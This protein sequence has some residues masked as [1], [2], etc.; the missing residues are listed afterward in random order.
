M[1][2][3]LAKTVGK[4]IRKKRREL[5]YTLC[6]VQKLTGVTQSFLSG[7]ER[8]EALPS[9]STAMKISSVLG[10]T[11]NDIVKGSEEDVKTS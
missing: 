10:L 7:V 9:L 2:K 8:G 1:N 6:Y 4:N 5:D 3:K 11:L